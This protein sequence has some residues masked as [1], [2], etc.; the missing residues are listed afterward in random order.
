MSRKWRNIL[1]GVLAVAVIAVL[2]ILLN[3]GSGDYSSKYAGIDLSTD[4]SGIGRGNTYEAYVASHASDPEVKEEVPVDVLSFEGEAT[5]TAE[6]LLTEDGSEVTWKAEVPQ[7]G[8]YNI[9]LEYLT[10]ESRGVDI[11]RELLIN[12]ELPFA[13]ASTLTLSRLWTDAGEVRKDNQGNEIRPSQKEIF[14]R[15]TICFR[16]DMGYQTEPYAFWFAEGENTLTL[17]AVNEPMIVCGI[18]LTPIAKYPSYEEYAASLPETAMTEAGRNYSQTVQ[19]ESAP[20]RSAPSLYARYD[21]SSP[22]TDP[23]SVTNTVLNYIGGDPWTHAGEWIQWDFEIPEDGYYNISIKARQMYQRGALSG[24]TVYI[25]GKVPFKDLEAVTFSYNTSWEMR[26]LSDAEGNP[27]RFYLTKG[28]HTIRMEVT[29]GEMGPVLKR[30][31]DSIFRLN[32]IYRKLLVLTGANPDRFRD[33]KLAQVYPEVIEAMDLESK[34]LYKIVDDIVATTGEKSDRAA[35][36]QTLAVQ[37][38]QFMAMN[39]RITESFTSFKDNITSLGTAMQNM[40]E[41]KLDVDLIMITGENA[42][43]GPVSENFLESAAHEIRSCASSF[44]VD[45]NSLGDKYD[46]TDDVLEIWITTGRDQS[47]VLKTMVDDTFT[48]K[49]GIKV[50]IKLVQADAILTAVVAGNGPDIVLSVSGWF[51]V[52]YAMRNAVE[53]LTQFDDFNKVIEPF[54]QSIID[55]LTYD[56]GTRKGVYGLPETQDFPL[57]FYRKDVMEEMGLKIP[58]TWEELIAELPTIQGDSLTVALPFP[59][60]M[61]ADTSILNTMI[62]QN[63]GEIYE[64]DA[65]RTLI[66]SEAGVAAFKQYVSLYNDYGLPTIF[67]FVSRFRSGEMPLG[68]VSYA[69][70]NTLMISAPEIRGLWDFTLVPGTVREDGT[71]DRTCHTAGL[72]CMMIKTDNEKVRNNAWEFMKWWVSEDAQVRF[73]REMESVLGASARYQ[74]ANRNALRRLAWSNSQLAVLE[75][76]MA[77]THG[78]PE[79]AGGY[80]TTR[81]MTNAIRRVI[82][83]KEDP[84]ETLLTYART[85]NE[86]IRIKR[87]EFNLPVD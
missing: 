49:S 21:R 54:Y 62:Y 24:R 42:K 67:D 9:R 3:Q 77:H 61:V 68:V 18:T 28:V 71:L 2:V 27:F 81:H 85:I 74:T 8:L 26:T 34:R 41:S 84:R 64:K 31:E 22:K 86:E 69:T 57:L 4:V 60:I 46:D 73:G 29:L 23:Y 59:D 53:D 72:C 14:D 70:Y 50:N 75:E 44:F 6:G 83:T 20:L 37:L 10:T 25:D 58:E 43:P 33:Y 87:R 30:V 35:A 79:I 19:G 32:Q 80:S 12:G 11:E 13:G 78:F 36:A 38:E 39:E 55:P 45:Y 47:T 76:Q 15:Q 1:I 65:K 52:N 56:N 63:G 16:D 51:A 7:A 40:S 82:T 17:K 5:P 48:A 66:D